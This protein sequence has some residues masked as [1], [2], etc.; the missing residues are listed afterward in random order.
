[1]PK[2]DYS[3]SIQDVYI[4]ASKGCMVEQGQNARL[5]FLRDARYMPENSSSW[6]MSRAARPGE[7]WPSWLPDWSLEV[8]PLRD[9]MHKL[10][11]SNTDPSDHRESHA[12]IFQDHEHHDEARLTGPCLRVR[13]IIVVSLQSVLEKETVEGL[14]TC[15]DAYPSTLVTYAEA[16]R[17]IHTKEIS[18]AAGD[19]QTRLDAS[20]LWRHIDDF[21]STCSSSS[22]SYSTKPQPRPCV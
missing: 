16:Y 12:T 4:E 9:L 7:P 19:R 14:R 15:P 10:Y 21:E 22:T 3:L 13:G 20:Y 11:D 18:K 1:L 6:A 5:H 8:S 17:M 2:I